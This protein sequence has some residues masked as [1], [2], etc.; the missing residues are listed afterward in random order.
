MLLSFSFESA[1]IPFFRSGSTQAP[2]LK[3]TGASRRIVASSLLKR[4]W[5]AKAV[6]FSPSFPLTLPALASTSSRVPYS[7][8]SFT[9]VLSPTPG[10]PGMLSLESPARPF[11]SVT[12]SGVKPYSSYTLEGVKRIVSLMPLRVNISSVPPPTSCSASRSPVSSS[13]VTPEAAPFRLRVP[14]RSSASQPCREKR[15]MP[16]SSRRERIVPNCWRSSGGVSRR[17]AL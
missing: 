17:P 3:S 16:M 9:A 1:G 2:R 6:S 14:S 13:G 12:C 7:C 11:Q 10:T 15:R 5:S 4:A 8:R